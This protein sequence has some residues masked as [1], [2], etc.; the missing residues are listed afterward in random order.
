MVIH[1]DPKT[2]HIQ[3]ACGI[4]EHYVPTEAITALYQ[5]VST[6]KQALEKYQDEYILPE[7]AAIAKAVEEENKK[8]TDSIKPLTVV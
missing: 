1:F 7:L 6:L 4:L 8:F 2:M 5:K 3:V